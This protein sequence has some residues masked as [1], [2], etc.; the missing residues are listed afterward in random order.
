MR[1][2]WYGRFPQKRGANQTTVYDRHER[3]DDGLDPEALLMQQQAVEKVQ[4]ASKNYRLIF[5]K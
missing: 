4:R 2:T 3:P 5:A 1:H